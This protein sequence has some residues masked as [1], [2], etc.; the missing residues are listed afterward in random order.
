MP[1]GWSK[2]KPSTT[3]SGGIEQQ[4]SFPDFRDLRASNQ[5]FTAMA[6]F[7]YWLFTVGGG[8]HPEG[9]IGIW[10]GDSLFHVLGVRPALGRLLPAG[11]ERQGTALEAVISYRLWQRR[12]GGKPG[13]IGNTADIDGR[14]VTIV[15][16]LPRDFSFPDVIGSDV[17]LPARDA[18]SVHAGGRRAVRTT[19][20]PGATTTT[21]CSRAW[22]R[23]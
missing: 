5:S 16:V 10:T 6:A 17:P 11:A 9:V 23:A 18:R 14:P 7:R 4:L 2:W 3:R 20:M 21:G 12:F 8:D 22:R 1:T 15:G 13:V 19:S